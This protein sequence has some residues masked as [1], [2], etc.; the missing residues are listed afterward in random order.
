MYDAWQK[1]N[2]KLILYNNITTFTHNHGRGNTCD[3]TDKI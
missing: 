2:N 3:Y 1:K